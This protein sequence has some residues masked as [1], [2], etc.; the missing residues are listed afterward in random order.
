MLNASGVAAVAAGNIG[1]P[2]CNLG[3]EPATVVVLEASS[4]QLR[5]ID[6]FHPVA[7]GITNVAA[8]HLDWH[9]TVDAYAA[10]KARIFEN[11]DDGD[12]LAYDTDDAGARDLVARAPCRTVPVSGTSIPQGGVGPADG[13]LVV[14]G[15][16]MPLAT[17]DPSFV[18][19]LAIAAIVALSVG[20]TEAG[21]ASVVGA[22]E[23]GAHRRR[24]VGTKGGIR[25]IDDSKATNPHAARAA[26][27]SYESVVLLAGGRNKQLDLAD[28]AP[29][30][31]HHVVAFGEAA[32]EVATAFDGPI[33]VVGG[34]A[35]AVAAAHRVARRGD[36]VLLAPWCASFDEF[37]SYAAR[38]DRFAELVGE[39]E[40][41]K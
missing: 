2:V 14:E 20:G 26:A 28:I 18:A 32:P 23:S 15:A 35:E 40:G 5:F 25:W 41:S 30:S 36:T 21:I 33:T 38:G 17:D 19:D 3:A 31:V 12:V 39:L 22:F 27:A 24:T 1:F 29:D 7:A 11:M 6:R 37:D 34:L 8:D 4:F 16:T 9:L 13:S 10:A